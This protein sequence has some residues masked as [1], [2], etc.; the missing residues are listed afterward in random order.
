M[1]YKPS[2]HTKWA[3]PVELKIRIVTVVSMT[4]WVGYS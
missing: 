1:S 4:L 3:D 2:F